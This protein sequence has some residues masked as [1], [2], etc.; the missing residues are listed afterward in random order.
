MIRR[1]LRRFNGFTH[2]LVLWIG[3]LL[4]VV[5]CAPTSE[6]A[7]Y[8]EDLELVAESEPAVVAVSSTS[9]PVPTVVST[10]TL[11]PTFTPVPTTTATREP[12]PTLTPAPTPTPTPT[13][14]PDPQAEIA[15]VVQPGD[16]PGGIALQHDIEVEQLMLYNDI[17]DARLMQIGVTLR[18]PVGVE[19]VAAMHATA[20]AIA[21]LPPTPTPPT[22]V[23]LPE[24]VIIELT[25]TYQRVNNCAPSATSMI[26]SGYGIAKS[27]MEMAALQ[28]P[29]PADKNVTPEEV[30]AS[31]REL[32]L[33]AY[34]GFNGTIDLVHQL[35]A[36]GFPVLTEEW[37]SYDG[38]MGHF[39]AVRGYDRAKGQI[40][41][42]DSFHGPN[43]WRSNEEFLRDWKPFN[44]KYVIA[45]RPEQE[46]TL[47]GIIGAT[48][49]EATMYEELRAIS[50]AQAEANP[51]DAYAWWGLGEALLWHGRAEEAVVA[52][53]RALGTQ[54]L[55]WRYQW[56]RYGY[57]EALNQVGRYEDAIAATERTLGQMEHGEDL[58]YHRAVALIALGRIDEARVQLQRALVDNP[59]FAPASVLLAQLGN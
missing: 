2:P 52:F 25:H 30:A 42:H 32:G 21:Q 5:S 10:S 11:S 28:K 26:L 24:R 47:R 34:V 53:E 22:P 37:I 23:I 14:T 36:A 44:N 57:F 40:L 19:R 59:R 13:P 51:G 38:G 17:D 12:R 41:Y 43:L 49:D 27:Q 6:A 3:F 15:Y 55:P 50:V 39:R 48:W 29:N 1:M 7:F 54:S 58:R 35:L 16:T 46:A 33:G 9:T 31:L 8:Q 56:Y 20:T 45:Y 4:L 18:I